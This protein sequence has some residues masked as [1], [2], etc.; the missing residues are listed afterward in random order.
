MDGRS[1]LDWRGWNALKASIPTASRL[2]VQRNHLLILSPDH[3]GLLVKIHDNLGYL[4]PTLVT[5]LGRKV[6]PL[7]QDYLDQLGIPISSIVSIESRDSAP[8]GCID[9]AH[10]IETRSPISLGNELEGRTIPELLKT[11]A[12]WDVQRDFLDEYASIAPS[13]SAPSSPRFIGYHGWTTDLRDWAGAAAMKT[14][15]GAIKGFTPF[16]ASRVEAHVVFQTAADRKIYAKC[17]APLPFTEALVTQALG[18][19][20]PESVAK[21]LDFCADRGW[22]AAE[23]V[24]GPSLAERLT[25]KDCLDA[26]GVFTRMQKELIGCHAIFAVMGLRDLR[27]AEIDRQIDATLAEIEELIA[28]SSSELSS[29][30]SL[31]AEATADLAELGF[32]ESLIHGDLTPW[33]IKLS[34]LGPVFLDWEDAAWGPAIVS[35]E[36]FLAALRVPQRQLRHSGWLEHIRDFYLE[37]WGSVNPSWEDPQARRY[38]RALALFCQ[39]KGYLRCWRDEP[40]VLRGRDSVVQT[41]HKVHQLLL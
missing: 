25:L 34:G 6:L 31:L 15:L 10:L 11:P 14:G 38:S 37:E 24:T 19:R 17:F 2:A 32:P 27:L 1:C 40:D 12:L 39:L 29:I 20:Y 21:T 5:A 16:R 3:S 36:I 18:E 41:L 23:D 9:T 26:I 4:L 13:L 28:L 33:N 35:L 30:S 7:I 22:W 8:E